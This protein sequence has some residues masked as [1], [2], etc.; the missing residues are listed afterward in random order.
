MKY[1]LSVEPLEPVHFKRNRIAW[2]QQRNPC[3][4]FTRCSFPL[5]GSMYSY[6]ASFSRLE[7]R[8]RTLEYALADREWRSAQQ[9]IDVLEDS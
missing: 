2:V 1:G 6:S 8:R 3:P 9:R 4:A 5:E 7:A